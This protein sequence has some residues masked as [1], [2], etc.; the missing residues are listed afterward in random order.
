[1]L[2]TS[3][4]FSG[5]L[6]ALA[7]EKFPKLLIANRDRRHN[8]KRTAITI[9]LSPNISPGTEVTSWNEL[10]QCLAF[11]QRRKL[12]VLDFTQRHDSPPA[13]GQTADSGFVNNI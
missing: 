12:I 7:S 3:S 5:S 11:P 10:I 9:K 1:M 8:R 6:A 4:V 2:R 13:K